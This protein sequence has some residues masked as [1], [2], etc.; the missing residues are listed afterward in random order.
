MSVTLNLCVEQEALAIAKLQ[1]ENGAQILDINMDEGL[2]DGKSTM[3]RFLNFIASEPDIAK[4]TPTVF[5]FL[6]S[7]KSV[8]EYLQALS[9]K[10]EL[11]CLLRI[12]EEQKLEIPTMNFMNDPTI[13]H[14][15]RCPCVW[16]LQILR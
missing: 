9:I 1:V 15:F 3:A 6:E 5:G 14:C 7:S 13:N 11:N 2:L 8:L 10:L 4:V 16:T 12:P